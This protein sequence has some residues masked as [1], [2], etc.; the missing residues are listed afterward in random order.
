MKRLVFIY[1]GIVI[2]ALSGCNS[3]KMSNQLETISK[4]ADSNPDSALMLLGK[5]DHEKNNWDQG[6]RM[7]YGRPSRLTQLLRTLS[8]ITKAKEMPIRRCSPITF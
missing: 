2:I 5:Y 1:I 6:D 7:H 3:R 8:I 4:I